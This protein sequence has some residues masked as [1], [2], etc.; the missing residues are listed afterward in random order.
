[1]SEKLKVAIVQDSPVPLAVAQGMEKVVARTREAIETG[2]R[3]I[4]FGEA[5][6]GGYPAWLDHVPAVSLWDHPGTK[7]LHALLL[8]QAIRGDDPRFAQLQ[9]AVDI[10]GVTVSVGGYERIRNS[11]YSTQFLFSPK[12]KV[13]RHRKLALSPAERLLLGSGDGSTLQVHE[14]V[15]GRLGQ[16]ASDEHWMPLTRAAMH[17]EGET[18]HVAAWPTVHDIS[19]LASAHYAYEGRSFVL[20]A[21]TIQHKAEILLGYE[22]AGGDGTARKLLD[23]LPEGQLQHG[24]SAIIAPDGVVLA[25]AGEGVEILTAELDLGEIPRGLTTMDTDGQQARP[26]VFELRVDRRTR[27]GIVDVADGESEAA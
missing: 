20:A 17:H 19:M 1:M 8:T 23:R 9:W 27:T 15:W 16:L 4:A 7:E 13:L 2:A 6:L 14:A 26:D 3:V 10:A 5:F 24:R 11:L 18:V 22:Q 12:A 25:Q 21:G